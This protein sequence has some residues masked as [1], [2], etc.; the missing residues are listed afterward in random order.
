MLFRLIFSAACLVAIFA[1]I[2][3]DGLLNEIRPI[4]IQA[5]A[6]AFILILT[7]LFLSSVRF[8]VVS[9]RLGLEMPLAV[10]HHINVMSQ[11]A[12]LVFFQGLGQMIFRS[13]LGS[14]YVANSQRMALITMIEKIVALV[15]LCAL[16]LAAG[17]AITSALIIDDTAVATYSIVFSVALVSMAIVYRV[18]LTS[19]ERRFARSI[20]RQLRKLGLGSAALLSLI[21]HLLMLS[22][23]Y[24]LANAILPGGVSLPLIGG[25]ILVMLGASLPF[26]FAGWGLREI[27]A[28]TV[29]STLSYD[30]AAGIAV[31]VTIGVIS[32]VTLGLHGIVSNMFGPNLAVRDR[33]APSVSIKPHF[34]RATGFLVPLA[35]AALIG[36]QVRLPTQT[37]ALTVNL[38]DPLAF[39]A[40]ITFLTSWYTNRRHQTSWRIKGFE[41]GLVSFAAMILIGWANGYFQYGSNQWAIFNR[42][43]GLLIVL[44]YCFSGA[45]FAA[46]AGIDRSGLLFK[47]VLTPTIVAYIFYF[48]AFSSAGLSP[49][50]M[51]D[52]KWEEGKFAGLIGNKNALAFLLV[53]MLCVFASR[54]G[55]AAMRY[56]VP[57]IVVTLFLVAATGSRAGIAMALLAVLLAAVFRGSTWRSLARIAGLV[58]AAGVIYWLGTGLIGQSGPLFG[59]PAVQGATRAPTV[60]GGLNFGNLT[61]IQIDR[62]ANMRLGLQMWLDNPIFG[63]GLGAFIQSTQENFPLPLIIH[64]SALWVL[65]EMGLVGLA[66]LL[67]L[68]G[69]ILWHLIKLVSGGSR[70]ADM[71]WVD[72]ALIICLVCTL[73]F[74]QVHD[75]LYQRVLWFVLGLLAAN[76]W[77][78]DRSSDGGDQA[79]SE[80][81][82]R[83]KTFLAP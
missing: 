58:L 42:G 3:M 64:N 22:A 70:F 13:G 41:W 77:R 11:I 16:G 73:V 78:L 19:G 5:V 15:I 63:A 20:A 53:L 10:A 60:F 69:I 4:N 43:F 37:E 33:T 38:A 6:G 44:S 47:A 55:T 67:I 66:L 46:F 30:P 59:D 74:S 27:S 29:F 68:P 62:A 80:M 31:A 48:V 14:L 12:G 9:K 83:I 52:L 40:A 79:R 28:A 25:L 24:V 51:F 23:Y 82:S 26:T 32:L 56:R 71:A 61:L 18:C 7:A 81:Q 39:L 54:T 21:I 49:E 17:T 1:V 2:P 45:M 50:I 35:I 76:K 65:A 34:E 57:L 8:A 72:A 36:F 75:I